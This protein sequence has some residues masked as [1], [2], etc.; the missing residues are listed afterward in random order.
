M[1]PVDFPFHN[2]KPLPQP[3]W[4]WSMDAV[5]PADEPEP[6]LPYEHYEDAVPALWANY[7]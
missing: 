7:Q 2:H 5:Y 3:N 4:A 6:P 1:D